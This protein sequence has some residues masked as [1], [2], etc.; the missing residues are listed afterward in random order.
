MSLAGC[1]CLV[2]NMANSTPPRALTTNCLSNGSRTILSLDASKDHHSLQWRQI[3]ELQSQLVRQ[4]Q[5]VV[6][7]MRRMDGGQE[8]RLGE[9]GKV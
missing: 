7:I 3:E 1:V 5:W 6:P 9:V 2:C 8:V 4:A